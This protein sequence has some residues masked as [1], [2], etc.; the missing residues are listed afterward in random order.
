LNCAAIPETLLENELFGSERGAFTG[1]S[2]PKPGLLES[3]NGGSVLLDE[4]GDV[5]LAIQAKLLHALDHEE[6]MRVGALRPRAIDVRFIAAT[7]RNL[8][9]LVADGRFRQDLLFRLNGMTITIPPLR[10]RGSELAALVRT[11][12][13][14]ASARLGHS[15]VGIS[16]DA[17][18]RL[19]LHEWPGNVRELRNVI[20]RAV[21]FARGGRIGVEHFEPAQVPTPSTRPGAGNLH[22]AVRELEHARIAEALEQCG[23]NQVETAK[24]LG[25]SRGTLRS[26]M[27][28]L[29][30]LPRK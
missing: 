30:L 27:K 2:G 3:A 5:P 25:I 21:L 6:V 20:V 19:A 7:N 17:L 10:E 23:H 26:R 16:E 18:S 24:R 28:E 11:F 4:V 13:A 12:I 15:E 29:G 14:E 1:A 22:G 9:E 8:D